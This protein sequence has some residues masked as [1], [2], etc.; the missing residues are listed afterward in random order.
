MIV[1]RLDGALQP[2]PPM[3]LGPPDSLK[4]LGLLISR[5]ENSRPRVVFSC[6]AGGFFPETGNV[7]IWH[8]YL[9]PLP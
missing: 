4:S 8:V 6:V 2:L 3:L 7:Q 9:Q 1:F 5:H